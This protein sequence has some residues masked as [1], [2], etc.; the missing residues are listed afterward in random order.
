MKRLAR[1]AVAIVVSALAL[2]ASAEI[3]KWK[4]KDGSTHFSDIPPARS[5]VTTV[6][7]PAPTPASPPAAAAAEEGNADEQT[8]TTENKADP[9]TA[10]NKNAAKSTAERDLEFRERRA[11]A[12]ADKAKA[13]KNAAEAAHR[14][15]GCERARNQHAVLTNGQRILR[16]TADGGRE[17]LSAEDRAAEISRA[18]EQIDA[19]CN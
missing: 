3:Y 2:P 9:A 18:Q 12:A 19:F 7:T 13:D 10:P 1:I 8:G 4:D 6:N 14:S 11:A 5:N 16:P 15:E 17:F